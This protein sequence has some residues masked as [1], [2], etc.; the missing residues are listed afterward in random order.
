MPISPL[1]SVVLPVFNGMPFLP[2][3]IG[4]LLN[5]TLADIEVLVIDDGSTDVTGDWLRRCQ[6]SRVKVVTLPHAGIVAA[7]NAGLDLAKGVFVAR[8]DADD[9]CHPERLARQVDS[10]LKRPE[11]GLIATTARYWADDAVG[12]GFRHFVHWNNQLLDPLAIYLR[13]FVESPLIH[14]TVMFRKDLVAR[15]GGYRDGE[16]P[17]DYE[18]WLRWLSH[19]VRMAKLDWPGLDWRERPARLSRADDRYATEAFYRLKTRYLA[20]WLLKKGLSK[21]R[22]V[23]WGAGRISRQRSQLLAG[24]GI[25]VIAY[26]DVD[27]HKVGQVVHGRKVLSPDALPGP[28]KVFVLSYVANRGAGVQ[29]T[30]FLTSNGYIEGRDFLLVA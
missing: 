11:L 8:M 29:I 3:A 17:E 21:G 14:P 20:E 24:A 9:R 28:G 25:E 5:Q 22:V 2:E 27:P 13:R 1:V 18:L 30:E 15:F 23:V 12:E 6:D 26:V 19:G 7:L 10:L 4:S 16:F